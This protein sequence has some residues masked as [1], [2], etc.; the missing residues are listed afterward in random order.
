MLLTSCSFCAEIVAEEKVQKRSDIDFS[1]IFECLLNRCDKIE[2]I[3]PGGGVY[4][5][6]ELM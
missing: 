4:A 1:Y 5:K 6:Y 3:P 2:G